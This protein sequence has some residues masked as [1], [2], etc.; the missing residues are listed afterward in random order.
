MR[1]SVIIPAY[2]EYPLLLRQVHYLKNIPSGK[3]VEVII[4]C[5]SLNT[6]N[7][8]SLELCKVLSSPFHNRA[9]QMNFGVR[10]A[11]GDVLMFLHADVLP[12]ET[13]YEDIK[14]AQEKGFL[15]GF[16]AYR[17]Q[18]SSLWLNINS[19][20]TTK[21]G[22]FAGGGDQIHFMSRELFEHMGGYDE[23]MAIMEDFDFVRRY[24]KIYSKYAIVKNKAVV[25]SRKYHNRSWIH[26]NF[27]NAVAFSMFL[28]NADSVKIKKVYERILG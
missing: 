3:N 6:D 11:T 12:P 22:M 15:F 5:S 27:A 9:A 26:V 7:T 4:S 14:K 28:W 16:F 8:P 17:F 10:E 1:L 19:F 23:N 21:P 18:P 25:S 2:N 24:K 13:Y 20:F